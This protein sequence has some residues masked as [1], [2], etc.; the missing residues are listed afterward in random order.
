KTCSSRSSYSTC[1]SVA[2]TAKVFATNSRRI[3]LLSVRRQIIRFSHASSSL[4]NSWVRLGDKFER[5]FSISSH[6]L[7][8]V[9]SEARNFF[10]L[11]DRPA[12]SCGI[13]GRY[14]LSRRNLRLRLP[15][16]VEIRHTLLPL[17]RA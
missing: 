15:K 16:I 11:S 14:Q 7:G 3:S 4:Y 8:R 6:S 10:G 2:L 12:F 5:A 13:Y 9:E 1:I 17:F